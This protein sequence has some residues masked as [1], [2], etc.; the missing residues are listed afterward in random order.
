MKLF[1]ERFES[2]V[3]ILYSFLCKKNQV[4]NIKGMISRAIYYEAYNRHTFNITTV[5][6]VDHLSV[7]GRKNSNILH[8]CTINIRTSV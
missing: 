5:M 6:E 3:T 2:T 7:E 8:Y 4:Y 1:Q